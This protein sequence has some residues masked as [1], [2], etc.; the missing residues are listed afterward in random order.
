MYADHGGGIG[1]NGLR[2]MIETAISEAVRTERERIVAILR[3]ESEAYLENSKKCDQS[4]NTFGG[5]MDIT[6]S[7]ALGRMIEMIEEG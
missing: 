1:K 4:G 7:C 2:Q 6:S 3:A 5:T